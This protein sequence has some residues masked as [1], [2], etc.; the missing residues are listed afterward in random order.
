VAGTADV[1]MR[2][3][4]TGGRLVSWTGSVEPVDPT[5]PRWDAHAAAL[6]AVR[7][8]LPDPAQALAQWRTTATIVRLTPLDATDER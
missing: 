3:K 6:L 4:D 5:D 2:S 8:N 1:V 7:L